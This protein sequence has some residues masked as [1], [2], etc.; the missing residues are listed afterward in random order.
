[1]AYLNSFSAAS[2][3]KDLNKNNKEFYFEFKDLSYYLNALAFI[4]FNDEILVKF[5]LNKLQ[6]LLAPKNDIKNEYNS[7]DNYN[8][9]NVLAT[10]KNNDLAISMIFASFVHLNLKMILR[11]LKNWQAMVNSMIDYCSVNYTEKNAKNLTS[12]IWF[13]IYIDH[14]NIENVFYKFMNLISTEFN[15]LSKFDKVVLNQSLIL[16]FL[17][18]KITYKT[19]LFGIEQIRELNDFSL[20]FEKSRRIVQ[21]K[22][23]EKHFENESNS[24][25]I[26]KTL[27]K[28]SA[29][30]LKKGLTLQK[31][32]VVENS[33]IA[34]AF[35]KQK[36]LLIE[37][38][39]HYVILKDKS[40]N[41]YNHIKHEKYEE[42]GF[43]V[44]KIY[45][46]DFE[47]L[48]AKED[49]EKLFDYL[50]EKIDKC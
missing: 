37:V 38:Y 13:M 26:K 44:L 3:K 14:Q 12:I 32:Y 21:K 8:N 22:Y 2:N 41:G 4:N 30:L 28:Y 6:N 1:M 9:A 7:L 17:R 36:N 50:L 35:I 27:E 29:Y 48:I 43:N 16:L 33:F 20:D 15:K 18:H 25:L 47:Y 19:Q 24:E 39:D 42:L 5:F 45:S 46:N 23:A 11:N 10:N 40:L 34:D 49:E 31:D